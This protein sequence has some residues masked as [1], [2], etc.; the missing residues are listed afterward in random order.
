MVSSCFVFFSG[1]WSSIASLVNYFTLLPL[2]FYFCH[3]GCSKTLPSNLDRDAGIDNLPDHAPATIVYEFEGYL[4][5]GQEPLSY[6][7][8]N[9]H[10]SELQRSPLLDNLDTE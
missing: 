3:D 5:N 4:T 2:L 10:E 7:S 6:Q 8:H 1:C 9:D